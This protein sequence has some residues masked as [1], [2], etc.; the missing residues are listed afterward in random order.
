MRQLEPRYDVS[1]EEMRDYIF[2]K[3]KNANLT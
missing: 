3:L 2:Q 1:K